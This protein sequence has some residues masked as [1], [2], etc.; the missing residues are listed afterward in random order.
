MIILDISLPGEDGMAIS[1]RLNQTHPEYGI[2]MLTARNTTE[3]KITGMHS[4]ADNYLVKPVDFR[5]LEAVIRSLARRLEKT[6]K[7]VW[8]SIWPAR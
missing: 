1:R 6:V 3:D 4:G 5:E 2:I 8:G 7:P